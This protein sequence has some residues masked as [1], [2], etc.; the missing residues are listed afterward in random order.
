MVVDT[1]SPRQFKKSHLKNSINI[2]D[3]GSFETWLGSVI[4]PE[5]K[6]YLVAETEEKREELIARVAKIGYEKQIEGAFILNFA[7]VHS[8]VETPS[9]FT[10]E[11][12]FTILDVRSPKEVA[13]RKVFENAVNIPLYELRER[14]GEV[15]T[16]KPIVVH[17]AAG[18]RSAVGS[19]ILESAIDS[20][21]VYD[22]GEA[23]KTY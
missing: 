22:L 9:N 12:K 23:I 7:P 1:R 2:P 3:G 17:C 20:V 21:S 10:D 18:Y 15:P 13:T 4:S 11:S 14:V 6:F 16:N 19:S 8:E 5:E